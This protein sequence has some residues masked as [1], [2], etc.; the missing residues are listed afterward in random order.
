MR[1]CRVL[2]CPKTLPESESY[3]ALPC[4]TERIW[5]FSRKPFGTALHNNSL[6]D[7]VVL[8]LALLLK[9]VTDGCLNP[10]IY[11]AVHNL[12]PI[13]I[14]CM[15][16]S[17]HYSKICFCLTWQIYH[18]SQGIYSLLLLSAN[19]LFFARTTVQNLLFSPTW[20]SFMH[21]FGGLAW[22]LDESATCDSILCKY[23]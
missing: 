10:K 4:S 8:S 16:P 22:L 17:G 23:S 2:L 18:Y 14:F 1:N 6:H 11:L 12:R 19:C 5:P 9:C 21:A 3:R 13:R 15:A 20:C 7:I